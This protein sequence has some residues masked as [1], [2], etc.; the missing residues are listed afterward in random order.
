MNERSA[1]EMALIAVAAMGAGYGCPAAPP[2]PPERLNAGYPHKCKG[3]AYTRDDARA[4]R[5]RIAKWRAKK[6]K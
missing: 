5:K 2:E 1:A 3:R 4:R 6:K